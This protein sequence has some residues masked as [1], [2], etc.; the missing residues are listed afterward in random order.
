MRNLV[1]LGG[2]EVLVD[3]LLVGLLLHAVLVH[4]VDLGLQKLLLLELEQLL[5]VLE[6]LLT[7]AVLLLEQERVLGRLLDLGLEVGLQLLLHLSLLPRLALRLRKLRST[8][9]PAARSAS[10]TVRPFS[11]SL[12]APRSA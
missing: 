6:V 2:V 3:H 11:A 7:G 10:S 5:G 12:S 4:L 9:W 8:S 1:V